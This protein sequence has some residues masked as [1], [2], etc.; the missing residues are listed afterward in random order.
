MTRN[1]PTTFLAAT[2]LSLLLV[3]LSDTIMCAQTKIEG[4]I[5]GRSGAKVILQ[6]ADSAKVVVLLTDST[7]VGQVQGV[8]KARNKKMSMAALVPGLPIQVEGT[9]NAENE[10]VASKAAAKGIPPHLIADRGI[11]VETDCPCRN[12]LRSSAKAWA[13]G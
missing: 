6:T 8:L 4:V 11:A 3:G 7:D 13:V 12:R 5:R 10:M 9:Y 1:K 2:I